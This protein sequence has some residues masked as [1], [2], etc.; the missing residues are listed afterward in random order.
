MADKG[1]VV[2]WVI[3][4]L[5]LL[6]LA[7]MLTAVLCLSAR[8]S[9][10]RTIKLPDGSRLAVLGASLGNQPF[11]TDKPWQKGLRRWLPTNLQGWLPV[12]FSSTPRWSADELPTMASNSL[13]VWFTYVNAK[14][15]NVTTA[16]GN[17]HLWSSSSWPPGF[18]DGFMEVHGP[19]GVSTRTQ[20]LDFDATS[21][22]GTVSLEGAVDHPLTFEFM[23]N[24]AE[25]LRLA[26][27]GFSASAH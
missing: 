27:P 6:L 24:P 18:M 1:K 10:R 20:V 25:V 16:E 15:A 14:G 17:W 5:A 11:T 21:E 26:K 23:V 2:P 7:A 13:A 22:A 19:G 8:N 9:P 3:V 4:P 12:P